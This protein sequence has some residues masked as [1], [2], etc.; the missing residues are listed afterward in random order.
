MAIWSA[1][2]GRGVQHLAG[3]RI[4]HLKSAAYQLDGQLRSRDRRTAGKTR[5]VHRA[6]R[7]AGRLAR[8]RFRAWDLQTCLPRRSSARRAASHRYP[9]YLQQ[10]PARRS[11]IPPALLRR[12]AWIRFVS[13]HHLPFYFLYLLLTNKLTY[14]KIRT[15]S[16][17]TDRGAVFISIGLEGSVNPL[18]S[19]E[20]VCRRSRFLLRQGRAGRCWKI[21]LRLS[22]AEMPVE[23]YPD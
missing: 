20:R 9:Q 15:K 10:R 18:S 17:F 4:G 21:S 12:E 8:K 5:P 16:T 6:D 22:S 13:F 19:R 14:L 2:R 23:S 1:P 11:G 3:R 7:V